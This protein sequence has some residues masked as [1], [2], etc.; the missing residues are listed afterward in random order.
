MKQEHFQF[1]RRLQYHYLGK[2]HFP[3]RLSL[4]IYRRKTSWNLCRR[5]VTANRPAIPPSSFSGFFFESLLSASLFN[6]SNKE[7]CN[8]VSK[9][10]F[11]N[12]SRN[13]VS[14]PFSVKDKEILKN[15]ICKTR[16][17]HKIHKV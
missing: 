17:F 14:A 16:E 4:S 15:L 7:N 5:A 12:S 8:R 2:G 1:I 11:A 3:L 6:P 13:F 10:V 9:Q